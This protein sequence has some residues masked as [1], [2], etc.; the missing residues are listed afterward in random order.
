MKRRVCF[1]RDPAPASFTGARAAIGATREAAR[2]GKTPTR[3]VNRVA[4]SHVRASC[5][6]ETP[7]KTSAML[8]PRPLST[9]ASAPIIQPTTTPIADEIAPIAKASRV[10][11][12]RT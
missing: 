9:T 6:T 8:V 11:S 12:E 3:V 5:Q 7:T 2:A 1:F 10:T 4:P